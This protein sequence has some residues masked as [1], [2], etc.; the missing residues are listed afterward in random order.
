M[1]STKPTPCRIYRRR[2]P[3]KT[4][5]YRALAHYFE[6]FLQVYEERF[7]PSFGHLRRVIRDTVYGFLD[8]GI[9][10]RGFGRARCPKCRHEFLVAFSC[11][12]RCICPSCHQKRELLWADWAVEELLEQVP[13]R[14]V[15][16]T[17][18][19]RLRR[20]EIRHDLLTRIGSK[21]SRKVGVG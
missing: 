1:E 4:V 7:Q 9:F 3:E 5:L 16:L 21:H 12:L 15:V 17:I 14:Q 19:K 8:C 10:E 6:R 20:L 18:A 2:Q 11:K 13:H